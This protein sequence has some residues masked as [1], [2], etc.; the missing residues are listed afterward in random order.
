MDMTVYPDFDVDAELERAQAN[1]D[2][3]RAQ[4]RYFESQV[5]HL[6]RAQDEQMERQRMYTDVSRHAVAFDA[7]DV[8]VSYIADVQVHEDAPR[9][10]PDDLDEEVDFAR[11]TID[12]EPEPSW[13]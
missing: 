2:Y 12:D 13:V 9:L 3:H 6:K 5:K 11:Y 8:E 7:S 4:V 1:I 10:G